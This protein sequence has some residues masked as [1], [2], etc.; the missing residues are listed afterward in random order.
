MIIRWAGG[1][2]WLPK[3]IQHLLNFKFNNYIE[4]FLGGGSFFFNLKE[5]R[6]GIL[7]DLNPRLIQLFQAIKDDPENIFYKKKRLIKNIP[8]NI[9]TKLEKGLIKNLNHTFF[10]I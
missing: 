5:T 4:P 10:Y 2:K 8:M 7:S 6:Q 3:K 9:I 1:K